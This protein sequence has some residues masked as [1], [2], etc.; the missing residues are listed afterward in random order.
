VDSASSLFWDIAGTVSPG[1]SIFSLGYDAGKFG[2]DE[3]MGDQVAAQKHLH[4]VQSDAIG[5]IPGV[6]QTQGLVAAQ[7]DTE[8]VIGN[9]SG[10]PEPTYGDFYHEG[11]SKVEKMF[12]VEPSNTK[13]VSGDEAQEMLHPD[14]D[15]TPDASVPSSDNTPDAGTESYM[16]NAAKPIFDLFN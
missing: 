15:D 4:D 8:A 16:G 3:L 12:G 11:M 6:G 14:E 2:V 13:E 1:T 5:L 7:Q 10:K 9:L